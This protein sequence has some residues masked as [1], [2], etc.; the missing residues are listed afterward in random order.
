VKLEQMRNLGIDELRKNLE[1]AHQEQ[2]NLRIR[3]TTRQLV[4]HRELPRVK[5]EIA[6]LNTVIREK[7]LSAEVVNGKTN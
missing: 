6:R 3:H 5:R 1:Q 2:F 4:N 7:E